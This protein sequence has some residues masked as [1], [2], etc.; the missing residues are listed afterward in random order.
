MKSNI[1][2]AI[3]II[4]IAIIQYYYLILV[5]CECNYLNYSCPNL[6]IISSSFRKSVKLIE[7]YKEN[8]YRQQYIKEQT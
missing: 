7:T 8:Q 2:K 1:F 6:T 4:K 5:G 3:P